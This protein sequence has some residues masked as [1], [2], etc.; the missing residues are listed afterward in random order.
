MIDLKKVFLRAISYLLVAVLASV[1]TLFLFHRQGAGKLAQLSNLIQNQYIGEVDKTAMEDAAAD[2]MVNAIG[3]RWSYYMTAQEYADSQQRK[4]NTYVGIGITVSAREDQAGFDILKVEPESPA[5]ES[6][7]QPGDVLITAAGQDVTVLDITA[8]GDLIR[9][10]SG[11]TVEISVLR[12]EERLTFT[13]ERRTIEMVVAE[14]KLLPGNVGLVTIENFN[15]RAAKQG[16]EAVESL[17]EQGATSLVFDVR[18]NPGGYLSELVALLDYLLPEGV[19]LKSV[20]YTGFEE[21]NRSDKK[22]LELPMAVLING[23]SYS[24]AEFF[25]AAL[26]EYDWAVLVGE[27][28]TGKGYYQRTQQL[29]DG[30]AVNLS[31][32]KYFTPN[33][34][35]LT[36]AGGL[37]PEI[38]VAVDE[39][40]ALKIYAGILKPEEDPQIQAAITAL[41]QSV[42]TVGGVT[43]ES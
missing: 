41:T 42:S 31:M 25:A 24:A 40:T 30:S 11:T 32:G 7:V 43:P 17:L 18:N 15:S 5:A 13:V 9:G 16:M 8:V 21:V 36:E 38:S 3:D 1:M 19:L 29:I 2:A 39:E 23:D 33:G 12:G 10:E 22:C 27:P 34:V 4:N 14:G 28:T 20:D 35:S 6:G 26:Q 37:K